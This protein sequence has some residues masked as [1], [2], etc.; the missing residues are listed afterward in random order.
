MHRPTRNIW[1]LII[2]ISGL[3]TLG[4]FANT[5]SP[6]NIQL[7]VLFFII[8]AVTT[9]STALFLLKIVRRSVLVTLGVVVWLL[10]R[11]VGLREL[12]YP[13]LLILC[14]ISLEILFQ[15]R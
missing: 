5:F 15:K 13:L 3:S 10:L 4:W 2:G 11:M 12:W 9:F 7:L 6:E 1:W 8:I 14:L